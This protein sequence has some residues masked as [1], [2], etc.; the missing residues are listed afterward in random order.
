MDR[1]ITSLI[2]DL[3]SA[4]E[5]PQESQDKDFERF[6]N[7]CIISKEYNKS[8]DIEDTLTGQGDDTGIDGEISHPLLV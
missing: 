4:Q 8:F 7:Y 6:A 1:I 5:I 3:L 2:E